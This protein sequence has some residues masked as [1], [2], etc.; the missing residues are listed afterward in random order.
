MQGSKSPIKSIRV[1]VVS[2]FTQ[3][4]GRWNGSIAITERLRDEWNGTLENVMYLPWNANWKAQAEYMWLIQDK[5][6]SMPGAQ[7]PLNILCGYSYGGGWGARK[8]MKYCAK[9]GVGFEHVILCDPVHRGPLGWLG[10]WPISIPSNV[11]SVWTLRQ[12]SDYP[13]GCN[14]KYDVQHTT[15]AST[16]ILNVGHMYCDDHPGYLEDINRAIVKT[17]M[18]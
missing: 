11:K 6:E 7:I 12:T 18:S 5:R 14:I 1:Y 8:L 10:R 2:G 17:V 13:R 3:N 16:R 4:R 15:H 9:R